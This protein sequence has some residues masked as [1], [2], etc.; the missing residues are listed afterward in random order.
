MAALVCVICDLRLSLVS[1][2]RGSSLVEI[3]GL[4]TAVSSLVARA[5]ALRQECFSS[6][7]RQALQLQH[8]LGTPQ[9][10]GS[11]CTRERTPVPALAEQILN[12]TTRN[13]L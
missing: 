11:A 8:V 1:A 3:R 9:R 13:A 7:N 12:Q 5:Q 2:S 4:L 6:C 10:M